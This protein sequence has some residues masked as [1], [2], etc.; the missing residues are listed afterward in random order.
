MTAG[1]DVHAER[2]DSDRAEQR[3]NLNG[4]NAS[5]IQAVNNCGFGSENFRNM[6]P[7]NPSLS[8]IPHSE[9]DRQIGG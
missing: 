7:P 9:N 5:D 6:F 8:S 1:A 3:A 2:N 4:W